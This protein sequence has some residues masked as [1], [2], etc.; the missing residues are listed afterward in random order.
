MHVSDCLGTRAHAAHAVSPFRPVRWWWGHR[1]TSTT[2]RWAANLTAAL[3]QSHGNRTGEECTPFSCCFQT[4][5][6]RSV[7][8][9]VSNF[10]ILKFSFQM[11]TK[12]SSNET[13]TLSS[14]V[15]KD[16]SGQITSRQFTKCLAFVWHSLRCVSTYFSV[17]FGDRP[18]YSYRS[19]FPLYLYTASAKPKEQTSSL[20]WSDYIWGENCKFD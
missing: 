14:S 13:S 4:C 20:G 18:P 15:L 12:T 3:L 6:R 1:A 11:N 19:T 16:A 2:S 5:N 17:R 9:C 7:I 8:K 10:H